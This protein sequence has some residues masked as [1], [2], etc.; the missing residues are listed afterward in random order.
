MSHKMWRT[1]QATSYPSAWIPA[2][3]SDFSPA[4]KVKSALATEK[5]SVKKRA[6]E[7]TAVGNTVVLPSKVTR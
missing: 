2:S 6:T 3:P 5:P 1:Y 7:L 4:L